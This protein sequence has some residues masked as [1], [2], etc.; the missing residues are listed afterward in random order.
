MVSVNFDKIYSLFLK[1]VEKTFKGSKLYQ[2]A[3]Y[4]M[5]TF[6]NLIAFDTKL[7][8]YMLLLVCCVEDAMALS[9]LSVIKCCVIKLLKYF[10]YFVVFSRLKFQRK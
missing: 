7:L 5:L 4:P 10:C 1:N 3:G 8:N 9:H 2:Y 6:S